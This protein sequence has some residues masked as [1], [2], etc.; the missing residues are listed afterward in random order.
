MFYLCIDCS[1]RDESDSLAAPWGDSESV[2][3]ALVVRSGGQHCHIMSNGVQVQVC[4][5]D[6]YKEHRVHISVIGGNE[7]QSCRLNTVD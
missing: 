1:V 3:G 5:V 2:I 4:R 6:S 7:I